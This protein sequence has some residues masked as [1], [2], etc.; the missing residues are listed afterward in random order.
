MF[1][2]DA[3]LRCNFENRPEGPCSYCYNTSLRRNFQEKE[4]TNIKAIGDL[5]ERE[6]PKRR[7]SIILHGGEPLYMKE[8]NLEKLLKLS[9]ELSNRSALQTNGSLVSDKKIELFKKYKTHIGV[10]I[11][12]YW[13]AN[14]WRGKTKR[15]TDLVIENIFKLKKAEVPVAVLFTL[16]K[17]NVVPEKIKYVE[18]L[19]LDLAEKE[20]YSKI[21]LIYHPDTKI[22]ISIKQAKW[23]YLRLAEFVLHHNLPRILPFQSIVDGLLGKPNE[24]MFSDCDPFATR[25]V[26]VTA[27]GIPTLCG[28]FDQEIF[29]Q[30]N[31]QTPMRWNILRQTDCKGCRYGGT[32]CFGGCPAVS[33]DWDWR[34]KDRFCEAYYALF[35][36]FERKLKALLP[37][38]PLKN[39]PGFKPFVPGS[40]EPVSQQTRRDGVSK[41][42]H[43]NEKTKK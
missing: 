13:P 42:H 34:N 21:N 43:D 5:L 31:L 28:R 22:E 36:F 9:F 12:G 27:S 10:S 14:R 15:N 33:R 25:A 1:I 24:C 32:V 20:I 23:A 35:Q 40:R 6:F 8:E 38:V 16:H 29:N 41:S 3:S 11:D 19:I 37:S 18:K 26:H 30:G 2:V 39:D 4:I 17:D 7:G